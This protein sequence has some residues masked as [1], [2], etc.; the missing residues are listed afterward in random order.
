MYKR[1]FLASPLNCKNANEQHCVK[2]AR[3]AFIFI[4][5]TGL[6]VCYP[7]H[8]EKDVYKRQVKHIEV[9]LL[10]DEEGNI[11]CLGERECSI[12][13]NNQKLIEESPSPAV[14]PE[15]RARLMDTAAR[16]A[17]ASHYV[18][19]GTVEFLM[20]R[21]HNFYF[22]EMNTRLQVEHPVSELVTGVEIVKWQIRIAAGVPLDLSLIH[23]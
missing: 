22:M 16:A 19:A 2:N 5:D 14:T 23:I 21:D 12:Q 4:L 18:N 8:P 10:A 20:D 6:L 13:R 9:Q 11:V 3:C 17:K 15:L 7:A 1:Q